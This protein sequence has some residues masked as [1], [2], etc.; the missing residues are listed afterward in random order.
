MES[1]IILP[2]KCCLFLFIDIKTI[3][4]AD[5]TTPTIDIHFVMLKQNATNSV[6][7]SPEPTSL[8]IRDQMI[9]TEF[10]GI[11]NAVPAV[12]TMSASKTPNNTT[13]ANKKSIGVTKLDNKATSTNTLAAM[14][15]LKNTLSNLCNL[16]CTNI[17]FGG[18]F[19]IGV[20]ISLFSTKPSFN[21]FFS[22]FIITYFS[23]FCIDFL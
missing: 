9:P 23:H 15:K 8:L 16:D 17:P 6:I 11:K 7:A 13:K 3:A 22:L 10:P 20:V 2:T 4:I 5:S 12:K 19:S 18:T 14:D 21:I 1:V